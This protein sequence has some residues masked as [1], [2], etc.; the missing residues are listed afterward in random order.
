[1]VLIKMKETAESYLGTT[2]Q[3]AVITVP[4]NDV[5]LL[6]MQEP[7]PVSTS[8]VSLLNQ[9]QPPSLS[10]DKKAT[11]ERNVLVFDLGGGIFDVLLSMIERRYVRSQGHYW[12]YSL[13]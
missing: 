6:R 10:L 3:N 9:L 4:F 2:V 1:M 5:R 13:G 11:G 8:S 12:W 7:L